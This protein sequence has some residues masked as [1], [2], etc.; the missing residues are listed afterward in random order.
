MGQKVNPIANRLGFI[1]G[2]DSNWYDSKTYADKLFEDDKIRKYIATRIDKG[3]IAKIVIE[4]TI[5][6]VIITIYT[7]RPG[8][9]IGK[10]GK[11]VENIREELKQ[12]TSKGFFVTGLSGKILIQTV[13]SLFVYLVIAILAAS[14]CLF[15]IQAA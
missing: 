11:E 13:P 9:I 1:R 8:I 14:I 12:L 10:G 5:K 4:R 3:G 15:V 7:S 6:Q 2:W